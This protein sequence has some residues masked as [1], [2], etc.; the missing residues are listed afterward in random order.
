MRGPRPPVRRFRRT[1]KGPSAVGSVDDENGVTNRNP[2][3]SAEMSAGAV[4]VAVSTDPPDWSACLAR[5][6]EATLLHDPRWGIVMREAYGNRPF[7]LTARRGE[8]VVG[9]LQLVLQKSL[10]FGT[11]LSSL[12]YFDASG[13]LAD[14]DAAAEALLTEAAGLRAQTGADS[15]EL[16][17]T[18]PLPGNLPRRDDKVTLRLPLP[19]DPDTLWDALKSKV[20]SQARKPV[21]EGLTLHGEGDAAMEEFHAV[22][23][24]TM[25]DLG[26]PPHS[27]RFFEIV[28]DRFGDA[29]RLFAVR[30]EETPLAASFTLIDDKAMRVPWAAADWRFRKLNANMLLYWG[31]LKDGCRRGAPC[32]DFGRS[33]EGSGTHRFKKQWGAEDVPLCWQ[34]L[35]PEGESIPDLNPESPKYRFLAAC[36]RKLPLSLVRWMGPRLISKVS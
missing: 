17:H 22:Y 9:I 15:V 1:R 33:T 4:R 13:I 14:D 2:A 19:D 23:V 6:E 36:W 30:Q 35:L 29:V 11:H 3:N 5:H 7:Y 27:K 25:R 12:P 18:G 26:S 24:R 32:F 28:R 16:R 20:R 31:M 10:L 21:K 8:Q 34:Y